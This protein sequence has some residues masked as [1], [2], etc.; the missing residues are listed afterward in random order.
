MP[1]A[2]CGRVQ[3]RNPKHYVNGQTPRCPS[4]SSKAVHRAKAAGERMGD[5]VD[6]PCIVCATVVSRSRAY[7][8]RIKQTTCSAACLRKARQDRLIYAERRKGSEHPDWKGH[9]AVYYGADWRRQSAAARLRDNDTCRECG[10]TRAEH[11]RALDVHHIVRFLDFAS[12]VDA[13][14]LSN[15]ITLCRTCHRRADVAQHQ[16]K[17]A[18]GVELN[19]QR[20]SR[21][22]TYPL[23]ATMAEVVRL[24]VR[25]WHVATVPGTIE[26]ENVGGL[27]AA[28]YAMNY[29]CSVRRTRGLSV[30]PDR[31]QVTSHRRFTSEIEADCWRFTLQ[32]STTPDPRPWA[33][34]LASGDH[35][36]IERAERVAFLDWLEVDPDRYIVTNAGRAGNLR[37]TRRV[38]EKP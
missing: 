18:A 4:C 5:V 15:L 8:S 13:N 9:V 23:F 24:F 26:G 27:I 36:R 28:I 30:A 6:R 10:T 11:R 19:G 38:W 29:K 32:G 14:E 35:A 1:C 37:A 17:R 25:N 12:H 22:R 31:A 20:R 16:E 33:D 7:L 34:L 3:K 21:R 2:D